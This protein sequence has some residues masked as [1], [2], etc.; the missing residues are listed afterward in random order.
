MPA[1][2]E[3][4]S[5]E[6]AIDFTC[7]G[8]LAVSPILYDTGC[9]F[10]WSPC[11]QQNGLW[12]LKS[13][14]FQEPEGS[15]CMV[16]WPFCFIFPG[17]LFFWPVKWPFSRVKFLTTLKESTIKN[18]HFCLAQWCA[19]II[20]VRQEGGHWQ[21]RDL[22]GETV[23]PYTGD[24]YTLKWGVWNKSSYISPQ[25]YFKVN[26]TLFLFKW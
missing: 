5:L 26:V 11:Q 20:Q 24:P 23:I 9:C 1:L 15:G 22:C 25:V 19:P 4:C 2:E 10:R 8:S 6:P 16:F 13:E 21:F 3:D 18:I 14:H 17:R 7:V 12:P